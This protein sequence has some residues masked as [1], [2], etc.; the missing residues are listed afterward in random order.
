MQV[1]GLPGHVIRSARMASRIAGLAAA[2]AL[3]PRPHR[4]TP[5]ST[6]QRRPVDR[7]EIG[8]GYFCQDLPAA[9]LVGFALDDAAACRSDKRDNL[10]L[11]LRCDFELSHGATQKVDRTIPVFGG[12]THAAMRV[13]H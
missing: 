9:E 11:Q 2:Q 1:F 8:G 13:L 7:I 3:R 12:E 5:A 10:I 6:S 4:H